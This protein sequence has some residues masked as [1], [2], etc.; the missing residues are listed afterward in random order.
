MSLYDS[1]SDDPTHSSRD[2]S[3]IQEGDD[4][5]G[6]RNEADTRQLNLSLIPNNTLHA[7][8]APHQDGIL[9]ALREK[10]YIVDKRRDAFNNLETRPLRL[11][12]LEQV[13]TMD[14]TDL[15]IK[16]LLGKRH[17]IIIDDKYACS[18]SS[19]DVAV[20]MENHCLDFTLCVSHDIGLWAATPNMGSNHNISFI[21]DLHKPYREFHGTHGLLSFDPAESMLYIGRINTEDIW[22]AFPPASYLLGEHEILPVGYSTGSTRLQKSSYRMVVAFMGL[23]LEKLPGRSFQSQNTYA[24]DLTSSRPNF[25]Q[26]TNIMYAFDF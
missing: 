2:V 10:G 7:E 9:R 24:L 1:D 16:I 17:N 8:D 3:P 14:N 26:S 6:G 11:S 25:S 15:A 19:K 18:A 12:K 5:D 20:R 21:L 23:L 4:A 13:Y 22:L